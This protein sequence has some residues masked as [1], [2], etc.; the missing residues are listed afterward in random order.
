MAKQNLSNNK[1]KIEQQCPVT[2]SKRTL[3]DKD[4]FKTTVVNLKD[5]KKIDLIKHCEAIQTLNEQLVEENNRLKV[6]IEENKSAIENLHRKITKLE[7]NQ[8]DEYGCPD[9]DFIA[10]CIHDHEDHSHSPLEF[11]CYYCNGRF[12][13]RH[14]VMVHTKVRHKESV[15]HCANYIENSCSFGENCWFI[16]EESQKEASATIKCNFCEKMFKTK[17]QLMRHKKITHVEKVKMCQNEKQK[18]IYGYEKCWFLHR[19]NIE[20]A[21][22]NEKTNR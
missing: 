13:T 5:M 22:T 9:C 2:P 16:H 15:P 19:E 11:E 14:M 17:H 10:N 4:D 7:S 18:C 8:K 6:E 21:Y 1:R 20:D 3:K 12:E